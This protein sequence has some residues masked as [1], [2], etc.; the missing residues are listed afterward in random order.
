[1]KELEN[2]LQELEN[3][4]ECI[5]KCQQSLREQMVILGGEDYFD[6]ELIYE[7]NKEELQSICMK[8]EIINNAI[9]ILEEKIECIDNFR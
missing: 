6:K 5:F 9:D 7:K 2:K 8:M 4:R 1:M 3:A